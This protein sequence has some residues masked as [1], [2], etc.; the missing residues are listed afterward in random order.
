MS[1]RNLYVPMRLK[2]YENDRKKIERRQA[3]GRGSGV[4]KDYKAWLTVRDVPSIGR[5]HRCYSPKTDRVT[6]LMSDVEYNVLLMLYGADHV[7][8][9]REQ[10]PIDRQITYRIACEMGVKHPTNRDGHEAVMTTDLLVTMSTPNGRRLLAC[11]IKYDLNLDKRTLEKLEIERRYWKF[12]EI[13]WALLTK[14]DVDM[15]LV[16]NLKAVNSFYD[17]QGVTEPS[18]GCFAEIINYILSSKYRSDALKA[19]DWC[20]EIDELFDVPRGT[21]LVLFRHCLARKYVLTNMSDP[22]QLEHRLLSSF[23]FVRKT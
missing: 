5:R 16:R 10:F 13:D 1:L 14:K 3:E 15:T 11:A 23:T 9:I 20:G 2:K 19:C 21:A 4:L 18:D 8:E 7:R 12:K 6:H 22:E 17:M